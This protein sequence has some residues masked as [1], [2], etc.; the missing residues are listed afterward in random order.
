MEPH[1]ADSLRNVV[2]H[3]EADP[4]IQALLLGGS[5]AHGF[6]ARDSDLDIA[7]VIS[8]EEFARRRAENR[9]TLV[10]HTLCTYPGGYVDAKYMDAGF[11]RT[12]AE[13]GSEPAR[14]A[15]HGAQILFSRID[16]LERLLA[17][18][19]RYPVEQKADRIARFAAQLVGWRWFFSEGV[20]KNNAYLCSLAV[21]KIVLF[22]CR[23]VLAVN[24]R[25]F[26]FHKWMLRV[27]LSSPR[28][29]ADFG[30]S[31]DRLLAAA[32]FDLIDAHCR[33]TLAFA[34]LDHDAVNATW[35]TNFLRD[36][37]QTWLTGAPAIDEW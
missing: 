13:R 17:E 35:G 19:V 22:S 36:T 24:E 3:F 20:K 9:M 15:F 23:I 5:I 26:P 33:A 27:T 29:P 34:G 18:I 6:A 21:Q 25:L 37:E 10:N 1:H 4:S 16:G 31:L 12:V 8:A 30:A 32:N 28:Q 11:L 7:L 2:R 14:Y